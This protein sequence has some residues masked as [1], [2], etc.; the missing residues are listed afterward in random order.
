MAQKSPPLLFSFGLALC[1]AIFGSAFF[2]TLRIFA[3]APFLALLYHRKSLI[4]ALWIASL[5]GLIIDLCSSDL[6]IG[7]YALN[8]ALTTLLLYPQK[9]HFFEDKITALSLFTILISAISTGLQFLLNSIF[10]MPIPFSFK[11]FLADFIAMPIAD[12]VYAF[13][14]FSCPILLLTRLKQIQWKQIAG[15]IL[16]LLRNL[17]TKKNYDSN[18]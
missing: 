17:R 5:C 16:A 4:H 10:G 18:R 8:Y 2:S 9:R 14:W 13:L 1:F 6:R 11:L 15:G 3:F 7:I 12:G